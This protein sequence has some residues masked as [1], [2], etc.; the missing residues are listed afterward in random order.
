[1]DAVEGQPLAFLTEHGGELVVDDLDELL[2]G[3]DGPDRG[4][5]GRLLLD[6]L[7]KLPGELKADVGLEKNTTHLPKPF[8]D[9]RVRKDAA[10]AE[11]RKNVRD[12]L[13]KFVKHEP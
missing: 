1:V 12:L 6:P 7:E 4:N 13:G 3:R 5:A 10:T 9:V 8:L 11:L 2:G